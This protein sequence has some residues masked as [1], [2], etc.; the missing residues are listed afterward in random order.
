MNQRPRRRRLGPE[1]SGPVDAPD[2]DPYDVART[3]VLRRLSAA[4]RTR[5]DLA[6]DLASRGVEQD[7]AEA[8][9]D[10]FVEVGLIDDAE[11]ARMWVDSR[12]RVRGTARP[13]LRQELRQR[14]VSDD[15]IATALE[16]IDADQERGAAERL[17]RS[18]LGATA[19]LDPAARTR[20]LVGLLVRRGYASGMAFGVVREVL[21]AVVDADVDEVT[22][23]A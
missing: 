21:G 12:Q 1:P 22:A 16:Q 11:F 14:G 20:R 18:R 4:P 10:R 17:V 13:V 3:I 7:V 8:V 15:V 23:D 5:A 2:A 6:D 19:R 9:L